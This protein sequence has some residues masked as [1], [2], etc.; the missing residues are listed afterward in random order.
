MKE[1]YNSIAIAGPDLVVEFE[2]HEIELDIPREGITL[3]EGWKITPL[4]APVVRTCLPLLAIVIKMQCHYY[5]TVYKE[6]H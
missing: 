1:R 4:I 3:D 2:S 5:Y 6:T